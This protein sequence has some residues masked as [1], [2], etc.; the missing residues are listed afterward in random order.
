MAKEVNLMRGL[1]DEDWL[2]CDFHIHTSLSDGKI[3][4][5]EVVDLYGEHGFDA[6]SITDHILD[7]YT[8]EE[9]IKN[10]EP[11]NVIKE[12]DFK[13]YLKLLWDEAKRAW[14][15][16]NM[17]LIPGV[18]VTNNHDFYHILVIDV[19]EYIDPTLPVEEIVKRAKEQNAL[20]IAA[21]PDKKKQDQVHH[22]WHLWKNQ[23]KFRDLFD[24][25]EVA[26]RDDLFNSIGV[27]KYNYIANSDFHEPRHIY[28][29]KTL[30]KAEK[31][32][33]ALKEA[34]R[35][36]EYVAIYLMRGKLNDN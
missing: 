17:L 16:Y 29:W 19:K 31:N 4:L 36:N 13:D 23:E 1:N 33:E 32:T 3:P 11:I 18:E 22:S 12:E 27:K 15:K 8:L 6:I 10:G 20:V 9:R 28:S 35:N 14:E 34:I 2:L 21:H 7:R 25:W 24:A 5:R 26:N 30:I